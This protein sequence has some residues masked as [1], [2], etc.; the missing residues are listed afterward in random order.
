[1]D[2]VSNMCVKIDDHLALEA[3]TQSKP[4]AVTVRSSSADRI[5]GRHI[6]ADTMQKFA[7]FDSHPMKLLNNF[8]GC[9]LAFILCCW[10]KGLL[11]QQ[12]QQEKEG[13]IVFSSHETQ[14]PAASVRSF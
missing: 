6:S 1:M 7:S 10:P 2:V 9:A 11:Q 14:P 13:V 4:T 3:W 12:Q 5:L 8:I